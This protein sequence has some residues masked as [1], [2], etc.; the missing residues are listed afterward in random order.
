MKYHIYVGQ[1]PVASNIITDLLRV[2]LILIPWHVTCPYWHVRRVR[3]LPCV[4]SV[5]VTNTRRVV[6]VYCLGWNWITLWHA[7]LLLTFRVRQQPPLFSNTTNSPWQVAAWVSVCW[8]SHRQVVQDVR[9]LLEC[10]RR[11]QRTWVF[12]LKTSSWVVS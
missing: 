5:I 10:N 7:H 3:H 8:E 1:R 2:V 6:S 11:F 4:I 12:V 9:R